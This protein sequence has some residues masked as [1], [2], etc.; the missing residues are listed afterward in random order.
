LPWYAGFFCLPGSKWRIPLQNV[1]EGA[2]WWRAIIT[3]TW[4][5]VSQVVLVSRSLW[6]CMTISKFS[7]HID[8]WHIC[9]NCTHWS[10]EADWDSFLLF[11]QLWSHIIFHSFLLIMSFDWRHNRPYLQSVG[12]QLGS[13][14]NKPLAHSYQYHSSLPFWTWYCYVRELSLEND[15]T[16]MCCDVLSHSHW[17]NILY[18]GRIHVCTWTGYHKPNSAILQLFQMCACAGLGVAAVGPS[19]QTA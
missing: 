14:I 19:F 15:G 1:R 6:I 5:V 10:K 9:S 3:S 12:S 13:M 2:V 11:V 16:E 18:A 4:F 17:T 7:G 8:Y